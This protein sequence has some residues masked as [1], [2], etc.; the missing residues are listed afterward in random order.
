MVKQVDFNQAIQIAVVMVVLVISS[1]IA[2][3][4]SAHLIFSATDS[5]GT[6][7]FWKTEP[8]KRIERW[9]HVM[10]TPNPADPIIPDAGK[11]TL[12]KKVACFGG[13][14]IR[15]DGL[16]LYCV[17]RSGFQY[18]L[19]VTKLA[20]KDGKRLTPWPAG[21]QQARAVIPSGQVFIV[22]LPTPDSYDSRYF[23]PISKERL[24]GYIMPLL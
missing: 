9:Q 18:D 21:G 11:V 3:Y 8:P 22:G 10:V 14:T 17:D 5:L 2:R 4:L 13:E 1:L 24:C 16:H 12:L 15:R 19:G 6:H 20:T 7:V 23:G